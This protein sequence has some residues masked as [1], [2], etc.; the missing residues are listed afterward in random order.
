MAGEPMAGASA[1]ATTVRDRTGRTE[2]EGVRRIGMS[3]ARARGD[4]EG[5]PWV[6]QVFLVD[7]LAV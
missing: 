2:F 1:R 3:A 7:D 6:G 4:P 5:L